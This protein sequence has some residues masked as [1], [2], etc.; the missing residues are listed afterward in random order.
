MAVPSSD[1]RRRAG[2]CRVPP[3][4]QHRRAITRPNTRDYRRERDEVSTAARIDPRTMVCGQ[5]RVGNLSSPPLLHRRHDGIRHDRC[6]HHHVSSRRDLEAQKTQ[7]EFLKWKLIA[8]A[9]VAAV[10]L[11]FAGPEQR[12]VSG[13]RMLVCLIPLICAYVDLLSLHIVVR[14]IVIA[15]FLRKCNDAYETFVYSVRMQS[16]NPFRFELMALHGSCS[17]SVSA[18]TVR[19]LAPACLTERAREKTSG[20]A[21]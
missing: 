14:I 3:V 11:G 8:V 18:R 13:A 15:A 1:A 16:A 6:F 9:S 10:A 5:Q 7:A 20:P 21:L 19:A 12:H 4:C 17:A 2:G